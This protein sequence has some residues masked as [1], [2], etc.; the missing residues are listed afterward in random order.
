M[1]SPFE[2]CGVLNVTTGRGKSARGKDNDFK[3]CKGRLFM[4]VD[5]KGWAH[6]FTFPG[7]EPMPPA[8]VNKILEGLGVDVRVDGK[9]V[10]YV[11]VEPPKVESPEEIGVK[12][13]ADA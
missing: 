12:E 4:V 5:P 3:N 1:A 13:N 7:G 8:D 9:G 2:K 11:P 6:S 10:P